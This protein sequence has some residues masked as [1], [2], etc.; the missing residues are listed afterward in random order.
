MEV[1]AGGGNV[2]GDRMEELATI[3]SFINNKAR[4]GFA[5]DTQHLWASGYDLINDLDNIIAQVE[6]NFGFDLIGA[7]HLNDSKTELGSRKDRHENLG[8]GLIGKVAL[9]KFV[10][11][12]KLRHIPFILETPA[13]KAMETAPA[14]VQALR[15]IIK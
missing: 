5:L 4:V 1:A 13:L 14:E 2:I 12:P 6:R 11:H 7:I 8:Q 10:N 9:E 15:A 3:Y